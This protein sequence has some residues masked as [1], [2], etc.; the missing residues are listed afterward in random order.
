MLPL[1]IP[2]TPKGAV[3]WIGSMPRRVCTSSSVDSLEGPSTGITWKMAN[4]PFSDTPIGATAA[5]SPRI[6]IACAT[7]Y[8]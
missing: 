6:E 2:A 7:S 4:V 1:A 3:P 8:W 5:T